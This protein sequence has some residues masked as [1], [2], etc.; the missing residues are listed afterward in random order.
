LNLQHGQQ[1]ALVQVLQV[2]LTKYIYLE[3]LELHMTCQTVASW[4]LHLGKQITNNYKER[5]WHSWN[6]ATCPDSR[7][8]LHAPLTY[9]PCHKANFTNCRCKLAHFVACVACCCPRT[10]CVCVVL[11]SSSWALLLLSLMMMIV[12][13]V[14]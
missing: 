13:V 5:P 4:C 9:L 10:E 3:Q 6:Y 2:Q 8:M 11:V 7:C 14:V 12:V 1:L